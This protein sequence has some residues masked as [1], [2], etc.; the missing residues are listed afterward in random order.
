MIPVASPMFGKQPTVPI[1]N[2][3]DHVLLGAV[4]AQFGKYVTV[5]LS[6]GK[7]HHEQSF[8]FFSFLLNVRRGAVRTVLSEAPTS[9]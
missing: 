4:A 3:S 9:V 1:S 5:S 6:D 7:S 2:P 8:F